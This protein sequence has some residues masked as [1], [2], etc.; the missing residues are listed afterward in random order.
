MLFLKD[1]IVSLKAKSIVPKI[2]RKKTPPKGMKIIF[3]D[4][5]KADFFP[6]NG[7]RIVKKSHP[8]G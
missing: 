1:L 3:S 5:E 2:A 4:S 7:I 6:R 8:K